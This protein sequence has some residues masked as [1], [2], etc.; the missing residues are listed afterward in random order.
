MVAFKIIY[1]NKRPV[2]F[3]FD[4]LRKQFTTLFVSQLSKTECK[5]WR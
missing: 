4:F 3:I 2:M 1:C 5:L